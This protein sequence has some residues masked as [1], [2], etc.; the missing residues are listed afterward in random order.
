MDAILVI[1]SGSS[2][3]KYQVIAPPGGARPVRG[4]LEGI[5][6]PQA[7]LT[8]ACDGRAPL[9][10]AVEAPDHAAGLDRIF[11]LLVD[12]AHTDP[13][14][15]RAVGHRVVHGGDA[16]SGPVLLDDAAI[17]R[18]EALSVL[19]PLH[20]AANLAGVRAARAHLPG[21]PQVAVFDTAFH[22]DLPE[23]ARLY[24]LPLDLQRRLE[25]RRYG[26]HGLSH[27]AAMLAAAALL[28]RPADTLKL[29]TLHLGN[30]ASAC[31]IRHGK[32]VDTSMGHTAL[33]GLVM[34][35][36]CGDLDPALP[37]LIADAGNLSNAQLSDLLNRQSGLTGLCG[38]NDMRR[39]EAR[40]AAGD[41]DACR[42]FDLFCHRARKYVGAYFAVLNGIDALVFT[43]GIGEH[44]AAVRAAACA[45]LDALGLSVDPARNAA[46]GDGARIIS[47]PDAARA[48][49]VVPAD[50]EGMIARAVHDCLTGAPP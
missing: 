33:E 11:A 8:H 27:Q 43:G 47:P 23:T 22:H 4:V 35:S 36:R 31:A 48:I 46:S 40:M 34:G 21:T 50:E 45:E 17:A 37:G 28:G 12:P 24:A 15:L 32:S 2:S 20:N 41:A 1:N 10:R 3:I 13:L 7:R 5:G 29:I 18:L 44:S 30:G 39:I 38:D 49:L 14:R 16:F 6:G 42:A 19:A 25:I 9:V 26:F